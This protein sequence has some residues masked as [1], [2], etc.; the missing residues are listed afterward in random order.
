MQLKG[1]INCT[2]QDTVFI[3][4]KKEKGRIRGDPFLVHW[5]RGQDSNLRPGG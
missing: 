2:I 4:I 1:H 5:L 3:E